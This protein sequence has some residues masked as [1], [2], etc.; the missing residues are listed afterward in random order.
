MKDQR[1]EKAVE[2]QSIDLISLASTPMHDR[3]TFESAQAV[4]EK[5]AERLRKG[6]PGKAYQGWTAE[7][8]QKVAH[9]HERQGE[10]E[11]PLPSKKRKRPSRA[12]CVSVF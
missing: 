1:L 7:V 6:P 3:L 9:H 11:S 8:D 12:P 2:S 5:M 10:R 4:D